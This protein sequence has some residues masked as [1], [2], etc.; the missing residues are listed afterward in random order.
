[1]LMVLPDKWPG[2]FELAY[3]LRY[4]LSIFEIGGDDIAEYYSA[5]VTDH[6]F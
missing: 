3:L 4:D 1:M 5:P 6:F 2:I